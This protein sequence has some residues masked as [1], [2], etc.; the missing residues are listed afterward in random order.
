MAGAT[1]YSAVA[2]GLLLPAVQ[3]V[4]EAAGRSQSLNNLKQLAL[5]M[6]CHMDANGGFPPAA[7]CDKAGR[8]LLSWRVAIL[9]YI[10]H[11]ALYA[12]FKLDEPWDSEHNKSLI[13]LLPKVYT[14]P[15]LPPQPGKTYYKV[16][17][18]G[19]AAFEIDKG[20]RIIDITDGTSNT[21]MIV[22]GGDPVVWTKPEDIPYDPKRPLPKLEI[23]GLG[24]IVLAFCDGSVRQLNNGRLSEKNLR[25]AIT[26]AGGEVL[27]QDW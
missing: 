21:I 2:V 17:T 14:D 15:R 13:P 22:E 6:H 27:D 10:E 9:P 8:P 12:Q 19:G 3:R 4:R 16:F 11:Q 7:I 18:G 23:P 1:A 24:S 25:A 20:A 5:A 26:K